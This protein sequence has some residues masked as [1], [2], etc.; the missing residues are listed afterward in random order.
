VIGNGVEAAGTLEQSKIVGDEAE[1]E[2]NGPETSGEG[3]SG[4]EEAQVGNQAQGV[5]QQRQE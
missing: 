2:K 3:F 5:G 4:V 1:T